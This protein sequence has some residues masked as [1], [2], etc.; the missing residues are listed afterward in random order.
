[1]KTNAT[2][3][4]GVVGLHKAVYVAIVGTLLL[5]LGACSNEKL[6]EERDSLYNENGN[7]KAENAALKASRDEVLRQERTDALAKRPLPAGPS[8][9]ES[10]QG[11]TEGKTVQGEDQIEIAGDVLF[12]TGKATIKP[13]FHKTLDKVAELLKTRYEGRQLR[14]EGHTDPRPVRE[15]GWDDN[16]DLGAQRSRSVAL[17][18]IN[19][20][21]PKKCLYIASFA[22][23]MLKSTTDYAQ[24]RRVDI[25][26]VK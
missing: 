10:E 26:V 5:G 13:G 1:M 12:D 2:L 19:A 17:Y 3:K 11:V 4:T 6:H 7:L 9:L 23:N 18:L 22:D 24:D 25:V 15:S 16:W 14:V 8:G 21:V 20:G